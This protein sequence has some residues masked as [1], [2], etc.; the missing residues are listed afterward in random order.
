MKEGKNDYLEGFNNTLYKAK[1]ASNGR[2]PPNM[3]ANIIMELKDS[4]RWVTH[5]II[6]K[7]LTKYIKKQ[8]NN[9][10]IPICTTSN[11]FIPNDNNYNEVAHILTEFSASSNQSKGG[12]LNDSIN[13]FKTLIFRCNVIF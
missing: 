13:K 5:S 12:R 6:N 11:D 1:L 9:V 8:N 10:Q 2:I 7:S 3:V 4:F